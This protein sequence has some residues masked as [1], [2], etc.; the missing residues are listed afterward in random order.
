MIKGFLLLW[1]INVILI[2]VTLR[3]R[4]EWLARLLIGIGAC[5][6]VFDGFRSLWLSRWWQ[7]VIVAL[8]EV[9]IVGVVVGAIRRFELRSLLTYA[10]FFAII[11]ILGAT[12]LHVNAL[13]PRLLWNVFKETVRTPRKQTLVHPNPWHDPP[14]EARQVQSK[15]DL[16]RLLPTR[17]D[18]EI[19]WGDTA[20]VASS[21][22]PSATVAR[23]PV[24]LP[25]S[26]NTS[27][28]EVQIRLIKGDASLGLRHPVTNQWYYRKDALRQDGDHH[29]LRIPIY[30]G[31]KKVDLVFSNGRFGRQSFIFEVEGAVLYELSGSAETEAGPPVGNV[32]QILLDSFTLS[33]YRE[34]VQTHPELRYDGFTLYDQFRTSQDLTAWSL[35]T[36]FSGTYYDPK[37][38]I[39]ADAW[40][41]RSYQSG[42][43]SYLRSSGIPAYQYT[44]FSQHCFEGAEHCVSSQDYRDEVLRQVSDKI[45]VD[46]TFLRILPNSLRAILMG[47]LNH[48]N[49]PTNS[50]DY[51]FSLTNVF[52]KGDLRS[53]EDEILRE[54]YYS[55][56]LF[57]IRFFEQMLVDEVQR[58]GTG[59]IVFFHSMV[60]HKPIARDA[61]CDFVPKTS[62][63]GD[64]KKELAQSICALRLVGWLIE[65]LKLLGRYDDAL[66]IIHSDHGQASGVK[67]SQL[68]PAEWPSGLVESASTGLL[69]VKW[70]GG[71][72]SFAMSHAPAQTIDLAPT[73]LHHFG[74][75]LPQHYVGMPLQEMPEDLHR[76]MVFYAMDRPLVGASTKYWWKYVRGEDGKWVFEK[77]I[78]TSP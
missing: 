6:F 7:V 77:S 78:P 28:A 39:T 24:E 13:G 42:A 31:A 63:T 75:D 71:E 18:V 67:I 5:I 22:P 26:P 16:E 48:K 35:P 27:V 56:N 36:I 25:P 46:L 47:S 69:M 60:P 17:A 19:Q 4:F 52:G 57:T 49:S 70:P 33:A 66:I 12:A 23:L 14:S 8:V 54:F 10:S 53:S 30:P 44:W 21:A 64:H 38:G 62:R 3:G 41:E 32:Y 34:I 1:L 11:V 73:I 37:T 76:Q 51:G 15:I 65:Q 20:R 61:N 55:L 68:Q 58:P 45:I 9:A 74:L 2:F 50:W 43:F 59:Q 40:K 72:S 29:K